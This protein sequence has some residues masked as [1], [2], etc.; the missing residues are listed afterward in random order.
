MRLAR[1]EEEKKYLVSEVKHLR[2]HADTTVS[3]ALI[4][5]S[6]ITLCNYA[7]A[8]NTINI[9]K[10]R[11]LLVHT[12]AVLFFERQDSE[13]LVRD[14]TAHNRVVSQNID[15]RTQLKSTELERNKFKNEAD[16]VRHCLV[17]RRHALWWGGVV[18]HAAMSVS[19][20]Q[21]CDAQVMNLKKS[22]TF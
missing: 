22:F 13:E 5:T 1:L 4:A 18:T 12:D 9:G 11:K 17:D 20:A 15:L 2:N 7:D 16:R 8:I 10:T 14:L 3:I 21:P 19:N 6:T